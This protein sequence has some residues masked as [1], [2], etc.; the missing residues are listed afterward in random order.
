[1][2]VLAP[3]YPCGKERIPRCKKL[4]KETNADNFFY[5]QYLSLIVVILMAADSRH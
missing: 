2:R 4:I 3:N 1:M 5:S